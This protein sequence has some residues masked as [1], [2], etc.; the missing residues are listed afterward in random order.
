MADVT[1]PRWA[2][3]ARAVFRAAV[4]VVALYWLSR[5]ALWTVGWFVGIDFSGE[6]W[7]TVSEVATVVGTSLFAVAALAGLLWLAGAF[8]A[9]F[10]EPS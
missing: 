4:G 3:T 10:R 1:L 5:A 2:A 8:V 7:R 9:G 6:P